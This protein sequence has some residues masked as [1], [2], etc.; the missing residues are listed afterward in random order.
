MRVEKT[1]FICYRRA[2]YHTALS[3]YKELEKNGYD[4]FLDYRSIIR[5]LQI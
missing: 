2:N 5:Q 3:V 1:V 4:V